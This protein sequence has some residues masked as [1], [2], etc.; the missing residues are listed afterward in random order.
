[1]RG[2]D[3]P[4]VY[5]FNVFLILMYVIIFLLK[6]YVIFLF[7]HLQNIIIYH[8]VFLTLWKRMIN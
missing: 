6:L 3:N 4:N 7:F 5:V 1:M 8:F 2:E